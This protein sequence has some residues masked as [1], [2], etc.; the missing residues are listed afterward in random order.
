MKPK[1]EVIRV[2][3]AI[4]TVD[5]SPL[6]KNNGMFIN[7]TD[8]AKPFGKKVKD[9]LKT[10]PTKEYIEEIFKEDS[11]PLKKYEDL[12]RIKK[13]KYGG[14]FLHSELAFEFAG[15]CS[16]L[17]RRHLHKWATK[18]IM[19]EQA[20][21]Q[22]RLESKTGFL[23]MT[24]AVLNAHDPVKHYHYSNEADMINKIV[25]GMS[26]RDFKQKYGVKNIR[27][28]MDVAQL[29]E[30]NRLQIIN[31]GL[32]EIG[33][34]YQIRKEHLKRC[35]ERG[36]LLMSPEYKQNGYQATS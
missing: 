26:S 15:W 24:N 13:G 21:K 34:E 33:M 5:V 22:N 10:G 12:V 28:D 18:R 2:G 27:D 3:K 7:G 23:P 35:H 9:F 29:S 4:I 11:N 32:I 30:I 19:Q 14:T 17:F 31:T 6:N 25:L 20:W 36:M 16:P 1:Y 8:I